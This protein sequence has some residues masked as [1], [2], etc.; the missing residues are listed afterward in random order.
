[1]NLN[2]N[3]NT[4]PDIKFMKKILATSIVSLSL[5]S[6]AGCATATPV[7][8]MVQEPV[9]STVKAQINSD[10]HSTVES[11]AIYLI[12]FPTAPIIPVNGNPGVR[13]TESTP[14]TVI[15]ITGGW[16]DYEVTGTDT[17]T[18]YEFAFDAETGKYGEPEK[19][20]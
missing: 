9:N 19:F 14:T 15:E 20:D 3:V 2:E 6:L 18:G 17:V 11:V 12:T 10:V 8:E 13:V 5:L 16:E 4:R 7:E 1:L